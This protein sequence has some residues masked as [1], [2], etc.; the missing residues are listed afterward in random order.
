M[1]D[2]E[3][4]QLSQ[5]DDFARFMSSMTMGKLKLSDEDSDSDDYEENRR[6]SRRKFKGG[7][8]T[9][10]SA[11]KLRYKPQKYSPL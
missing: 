10:Q 11:E 7:K 6:G 1:D 8:S 3:K 4:D 2:D 5:K 9:T